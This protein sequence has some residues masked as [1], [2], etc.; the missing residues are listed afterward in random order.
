MRSCYIRAKIEQYQLDKI[1]G[2][3]RIW[4][5]THDATPRDTTRPRMNGESPATLVR[6]LRHPN[7]WWRDMAQ[8]QL[9]LRKDR[10]VVPALRTMARRDTMLVARFHALWTLEGLGALDASLVREAMRD[11]NAR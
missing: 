7:G 6:H 2:R 3:G 8:Q 11:A 4:R 10:S 5:L 1:V 9:V